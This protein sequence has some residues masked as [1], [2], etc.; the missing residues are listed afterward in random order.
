ME[1]RR[2][3]RFSNAPDELIL[4]MWTQ[5]R[6]G[7][8]KTTE[9]RVG[10][11]GNPILCSKFEVEVTPTILAEDYAFK[12][13]G[14]RCPR[15]DFLFLPI[16][17]MSGTWHCVLFNR[18]LLFI[19][20]I[21]V[22]SLQGAHRVTNLDG[23]E[24]KP[25]YRIVAVIRMNASQN[26]SINVEFGGPMIG[27]DYHWN[28]TPL[29]FTMRFEDSEGQISCPVV[30]IAMV[31]ATVSLDEAVFVTGRWRDSMTAVFEK[32]GK[33]GEHTFPIF[34]NL[35]CTERKI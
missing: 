30:N 24:G 18:I 17:N 29:K 2:Q 28:R 21:N 27:A 16:E 26:P 31:P 4:K 13:F 7:L 22:L 19:E 35:V 5:I 1:V 14:K 34:W 8:P 32:N 25:S 3:L 23:T 15:S 20:E 33:S 10:T 6:T 9:S 11:Y 12:M